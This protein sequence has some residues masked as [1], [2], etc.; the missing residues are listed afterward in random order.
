M[1]AHVLEFYSGSLESPINCLKKPFPWFSP[2]PEGPPGETCC[3][4]ESRLEHFTDIPITDRVFGER[5]G[6]VFSH[7]PR[8]AKKG[9]QCGP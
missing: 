9:A 1:A 6:A 5:E 8:S 7:L 4:R 2:C 3:R